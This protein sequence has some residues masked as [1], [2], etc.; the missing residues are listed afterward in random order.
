MFRKSERVEALV[1]AARS[2]ESLAVGFG[3]CL[4]LG[5]ALAQLIQGGVGQAQDH[6]PDRTQ[7]ACGIG[8]A[9]PAKVFLHRDIQAMMQP[10][11][12]HPIT[13]LEPEH[14]LGLE[15][16]QGEAADEVNDFLAPFTVAQNTGPQAGHQAR[17]RKTHLGRIDF[18]EI[19]DA[20]FRAA[21]VVLLSRRMR[22]LGWP[23]GKKRCR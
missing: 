11:F 7:D 17:A 14:A 12:D 6:A 5:L 4:G 3:V 1:A 10:A 9:H 15:L 19:Q 20:D 8:V 18:N 13:A 2:E 16:P 22:L 23:R 21:P